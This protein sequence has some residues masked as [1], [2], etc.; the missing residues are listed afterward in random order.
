MTRWST[1]RNHG[2]GGFSLSELLVVIA[3]LGLFILFGGPAMADA[4][5]AYKVRSAADMLVTDIRALRYNAVAQ[6]APQTLTINTQSNVSAPNQYTFVNMRGVTV[7][8]KQEVGVNIDDTSATTISFTNTGT[9]GSTGNLTVI[10]SL[11]V[12]AS[13]GDR[14][15]L[16]ITPTGTV[17]SAYANY[18]P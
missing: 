11:D 14:Y 10:M 9:T 8:R 12:N 5:K 17:S 6:R 1:G 15:T 7:I 13:R 3:L 2:N 4:Y 18:V 16:S